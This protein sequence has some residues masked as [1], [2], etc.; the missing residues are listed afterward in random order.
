MMTDQ[1]TELEA[2]VDANLDL[3]MEVSS[4]HAAT[5]KW[6]GS[7]G[8][9]CTITPNEGKPQTFDF[10]QGAAHI[11]KNSF[12]YRQEARMHGCGWVPSVKM[13]IQNR[14]HKPPTLGD[15]LYCLVMDAQVCLQ[16]MTLD[17]FAAEYGYE[18]K[19]SEAIQTYHAIQENWTKLR[20]LLTIQGIE[21]LAEKEH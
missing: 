13:S 15:V 9:V 16:H 10:Y 17:E 20:A 6:E 4:V 3:S 19:P 21:K 12:S 14:W 8:M 5:G 7:F 18:D 1:K 11:N 2:W